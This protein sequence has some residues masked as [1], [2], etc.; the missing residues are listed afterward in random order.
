MRNAIDVLVVRPLSV[1]M[2]STPFER[3][4]GP[5]RYCGN[6]LTALSDMLVRHLRRCDV[7]RESQ[8][9]IAERAGEKRTRTKRACDSCARAK[10]KCDGQEPCGHCS[11]HSFQCSYTRDAPVDLYKSYSIEHA[12]PSSS[13]RD[14]T[15][16]STEASSQT[17]SGTD[18][19][20]VHATSST[21][22]NDLRGNLTDNSSQHSEPVFVERNIFDSDATQLSAGAALQPQPLLKNQ[23]GVGNIDLDTMMMDFDFL[24]E[25]AF[26]VNSAGF[27]LET[28]PRSLESSLAASIMPQGEYDSPKRRKDIHADHYLPELDSLSTEEVVQYHHSRPAPPHGFSYERMDTVQVKCDEIKRL[29]HGSEPLV[30][31]SMIDEHITREKV[32]LCCHLYGKNF[33]RHFPVVHSP[34][35][36]LS[37]TPAPLLLAITIAGAGFEERQMPSAVINK[38]AMRLLLLIESER[39][40]VFLVFI[41][42]R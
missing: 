1:G 5:R 2:H 37:Q 19:V 34:S 42:Y 41:K 23:D 29:L 22:S 33:Q 10:S 21:G 7:G 30:V 9:Q 18:F 17:P 12:N 15:R 25:P 13:V 24:M 35:F 4:Q 6:G 16:R 20:D 40:S 31:Q 28:L 8:D 32:L 36:N 14:P 39:A 3:V 38:L 11:H 27:G 26:D